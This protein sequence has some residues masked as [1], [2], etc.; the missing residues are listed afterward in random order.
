MRQFGPDSTPEVLIDS[1][2]ASDEPVSSATCESTFRIVPSCLG[3]VGGC[4][5]LGMSRLTRESGMKHSLSIVT[6]ARLQVGNH[7]VLRVSGRMDAQNGLQFEQNCQ[8]CISDGI[9]KLVIDL[10][11]LVYISSMGLGCLVAVAK[12]LQ[13]KGGALRICRLNGLVK[14]VFEIT[15]LDRIFRLHESVESA[16]AEG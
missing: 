8:S 4:D 16:L 15:R 7:I 9:T 12:T 14:Q 6:I 2:L 3:F 13:E 10:D 11:D 1:P 5:T